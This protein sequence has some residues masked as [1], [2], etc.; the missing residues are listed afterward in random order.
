MALLRGSYRLEA[1]QWSRHVSVS[2]L[3]GLASRL[4]DAEPT[5]T[6]GSSVAGYR[7]D[8]WTRPL[9]S[10]TTWEGATAALRGWRAHRGA[11]VLVCPVD[12]P[13]EG[14]TVGLAVR[15]GP[16]SVLAGCRITR[17]IDNVDEY[18]FTYATLP[19][20][21]EQGEESFLLRREDDTVVF[22]IT[23]VSRPVDLVARV[24]W[25]ISRLVQ[26]HVI[27]GYLRLDGLG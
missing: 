2:D 17:V 24:G 13:A 4:G 16:L 9:A 5:F 8:E 1:M 23:A 22:S 14:Q 12:L 3:E 20:H 27:D 7:H 21:P 18:G 6:F 11:G 10:S 15:L 25:P 19:G 26:R